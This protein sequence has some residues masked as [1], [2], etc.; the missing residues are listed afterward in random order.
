M[1][2]FDVDG[3]GD[4]DV[5]TALNA[6]G[7]GLAWFEQVKELGQITFRKHQFTGDRAEE[8][9]FGVCFSEPHALDLADFDGDGLKDLLVGKRL[10]AHGPKGDIEPMAEPVLYWL[11]LVRENGTARFEPHLID[12]QAGVGVQVTAVD[13][14]GDGRLDVL[15]ASKLGA[16]IFLNKSNTK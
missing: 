3:D 13:M 12:R 14:D 10:W 11:R 9:K 8:S 2:A 16:F 6:H 7:W 4:N 1:F 5:V 15:T